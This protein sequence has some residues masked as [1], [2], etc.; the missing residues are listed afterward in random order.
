MKGQSDRFSFVRFF[1]LILSISL[2]FGSTNLLVKGSIEASSPEEMHENDSPPSSL[3]PVGYTANADVD[4]SGVGTLNKESTSPHRM[5]SP[6]VASGLISFQPSPL[7]SIISAAFIMAVM[8]LKETGK[9]DLEGLGYI[10]NSTDFYAGV[11][12][13][14]V[15]SITHKPTMQVL[16]L[17]LSRGAAS[18]PRVLKPILTSSAAKQIGNIVNGFT[19]TLALTAGF[20]SFSQVW[21]VATR[22]IP[23]ASTVAGFVRCDRLRKIQVAQNLLYNTLLDQNMQKRIISSVW[24][25]RILTFEFIATNIAMYV[26]GQLGRFVAEKY[27]AK[28]PW[29]N[30]LGPALGSISGGLLIQALP[31]SWTD[32]ANEQ[33]VEWKLNSHK[34]RL[35][36][37]LMRIE[38]GIKNRFYPTEDSP[39]TGYFMRGIDLQSDIERVL[40][41]R[42]MIASLQTQKLSYDGENNQNLVELKSIFDN[43]ENRFQS[44]YDDVSKLRSN[45][46]GGKVE[47][48]VQEN[49]SMEEIQ[50]LGN[51]YQTKNTNVHYYQLLLDAGL[52]RCR[53]AGKGAQDLIGVIEQKKLDPSDISIFGS[54]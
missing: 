35:E 44:L 7:S 12:G 28:T 3:I 26:G 36:E 48:W 13:S 29:L 50:R 49:R 17:A 16:E 6:M 47:Q 52:D 31:R 14:V 5:V 21:K 15:G 25:H 45:N 32:A 33:L 22:N 38:E 11:A 19:Y 10:L 39:V 34:K 24:N 4:F 23:E 53:E 40:R 1:V 20:E 37:D 51:Q 42:D 54:N 41:E 43:V 9:V 8:T 2:V 27:A 18:S 30:R 46:I